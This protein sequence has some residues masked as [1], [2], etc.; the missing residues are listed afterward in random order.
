[1]KAAN[2]T[3][4]YCISF[5]CVAEMVGETAARDATIRCWTK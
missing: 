3:G 5:C 1:M 4:R 2:A